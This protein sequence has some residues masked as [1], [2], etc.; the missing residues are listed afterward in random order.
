MS[1]WTQKNV[2]RG[3]VCDVVNGQKQTELEKNC[4]EEYFV[5]VHVREAFEGELT[6]WRG[7]FFYSWKFN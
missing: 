6:E 2:E 3:D 4:G 5:Y 7:F 1:S